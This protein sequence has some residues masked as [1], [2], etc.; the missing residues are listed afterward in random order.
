MT[1]GGLKTSSAGRT[2]ASVAEEVRTASLTGWPRP[3]TFSAGRASEEA[4]ERQ[5]ADNSRVG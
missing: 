5:V 2:S 3:T 1:A 4:V